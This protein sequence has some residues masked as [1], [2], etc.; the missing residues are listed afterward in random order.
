MHVASMHCSPCLPM[1]MCAA[2]DPGRMLQARSDVIQA[3]HLSMCCEHLH[4]ASISVSH[5]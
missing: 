5:P 4:V 2:S 3:V 1:G